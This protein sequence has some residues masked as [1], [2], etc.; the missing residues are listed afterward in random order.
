[1]RREC[2]PLTVILPVRRWRRRCPLLGWVVVAV[3]LIDAGC[4]DDD[5][6]KKMGGF[7]GLGGPGAKKERPVVPVKVATVDRRTMSSF[8]LTTAT[9]EAQAEV[10]VVARANGV[11]TSY[12]S[13]EGDRVA[14]GQVLAQLDD[15]EARLEAEGARVS[16]ETKT[17][18][19]ERADEMSQKGIISAQTHE[20]AISAYESA[21]TSYDTKRLTLTH[22]AIRSPISGIITKR[23]I[24]TG[25]RISTGA[26]VYHIV[27]ARTILGRVHIPEQNLSAV[28]VGQTALV[29]TQAFSGQIFRGRVRRISP[30]VDPASGTITVTLAL[31][32][33]GK[34]RP[35]MFASVKLA[36]ET[37]P[38][39]LAVP[40]LALLRRGETNVVYRVASDSVMP[41]QLKIGL[42]D[43]SH[44]EIISGI[45]VGDTVVVV[46]KTG[47]QT[48]TK[49]AVVGGKPPLI[50]ESAKDDSAEVER[51]LAKLLERPRVKAMYEKHVA[52]DSTLAT[53]L[54]KRRAFVER[55]KAR[56]GRGGRR[57]RPG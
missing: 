36:T 32:P 33:K 42:S 18:A 2:H 53:D 5:D 47:L 52:E 6:A 4:G 28:R 46:G 45:D 10:D 19:K 8:L 48:G 20:E 26:K 23:D 1:M 44:V 15:E 27:D 30:V 49:V 39:V 41:R 3:A 34:L 37:R 11:V 9:L 13:E 38:N 16:L 51:A 21:R 25:Q 54:K 14:K 7:G 57:G 50:L 12:R 56:R 40:R 31:D 24:T 43:T 55:A 22:M 29:T 17:R 35:G